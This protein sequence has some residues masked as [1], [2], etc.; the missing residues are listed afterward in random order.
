MGIVGAAIVTGGAMILG[1]GFIMNWYY[2]KKIGLEI[3]RFWKETAKMFIIPTIMCVVTLLIKQFITLDTWMWL[4]LAIMIYTI[5]F[6]IANWVIVMNDYE[7]DIFRGPIRK[8]FNKFKK[9]G[10][11]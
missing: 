2:W 10:A 7:K 11:K 8:I 1:Q 3:P 9:Q 6:A 4:L 5:V